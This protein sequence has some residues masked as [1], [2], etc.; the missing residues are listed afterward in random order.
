MK[1]KF[2]YCNHNRSSHSMQ[3]FICHSSYNPPAIEFQSVCIWKYGLY[4]DS[5]GTYQKLTNPFQPDFAAKWRV[6]VS[7]SV[8]NIRC[9]QWL[10][11]ECIGARANKYPLHVME[12]IGNPN[13][14]TIAWTPHFVSGNTRWFCIGFN[15]TLPRSGEWL[16]RFLFVL[17]VANSGF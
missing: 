16:Y 13:W 2:I 3:R 7:V 1:Y 14:H 17:Y 5:I 15:Q 4:L 11:S 6:V 10:L 8:R 12:S 9:E